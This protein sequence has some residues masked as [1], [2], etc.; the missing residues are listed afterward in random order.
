METEKILPQ[1]KYRVTQL[2]SGWFY[3]QYKNDKL[4]SKWE[5]CTERKYDPRDGDGY[6]TAI[7]FKTLE[8]ANTWIDKEIERQ[9]VTVYNRK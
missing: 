4:L 5:K 9:T 6:D 1:I 3:P 2:G 8:E 7:S